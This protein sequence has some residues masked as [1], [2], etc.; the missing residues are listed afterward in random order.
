MV[1]TFC[2]SGYER[3]ANGQEISTATVAVTYVILTLL[4]AVVTFAYPSFRIAHHDIFE[5]VHRFAG[6]TATALVWA[7][8]VLLTNDFKGDWSLDVAV[9]HAPTCGLT[10]VLWFPLIMRSACPSNTP[11]PGSFVRISSNPLFE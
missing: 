8:V 9:I 2:G 6:R 1:N 11:I 4:F 7:Q 10:F 5:R 3:V